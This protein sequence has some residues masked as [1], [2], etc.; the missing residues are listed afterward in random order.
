M[1]RT[2][3]ASYG[4]AKIGKTSSLSEVYT[5]LKARFSITQA[6]LMDDGDIK[7]ILTISVC[8]Q[9]ILIGIET[10]GDPNSRQKDSIDEF[11]KNNCDILILASRTRGKT[12]DN[13]DNL[14]TTKGGNYDRIIW[15]PHYYCC[16]SSDISIDDLNKLYAKAIVNMVDDIINGK[17]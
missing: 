16:E 13:I 9:S 8:G 17:L 2:V 6:P 14:V 10:Q 1:K 5:E 11:V 4:I 3:L 7:D 12:V 15:I